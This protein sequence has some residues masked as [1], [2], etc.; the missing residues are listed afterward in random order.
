MW[1][2]MKFK[3]R[4][5]IVEAFQYN[6]DPRPD[7]FMDKVSSLEIITTESHCKILT[8]EGIME[9]RVGDFIIKGIKN[10][11]YPCKPEIFIATYEKVED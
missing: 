3:K 8:L 11:I 10:E 9:G 5:I 2:K 7:W 4:P 1:G 6:I